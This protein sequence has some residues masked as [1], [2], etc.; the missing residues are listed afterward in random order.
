ML[1]HGVRHLPVLDAGR[2][3]IGVLDDVDLMASERRAPFRLRAE[4]AR[5]ADADAVA[6]A[7]AELPG[8]GDRPARRRPARRRDQP[9]DREHPRQRHPPADRARPCRSWARRRSPTPGWRWAASGASSRSRA[10]TSTARW[11]GRGRTTTRSCATGWRRSPSASSRGSRASG[12]RPDDQGAV[13]SSPLFARSIEA[14]EAA[15]RAWV[16]HPDRDRGLMLLS[17]AVES[18]PVWGATRGGRAHRRRVRARAQPRAAAHRLAAAALH[19]R[20]PTGF[21]RD[22]V[23]HSSGERKGVLDIKRGGLLPIES[24]ARWAGLAAGV[25]A[26]STRA[27]LEAAEAA[28]T[29]DPSRRRDPARR[30]RAASASCAWSTRSSSCAPARRPTT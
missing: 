19:E 4:I 14:W 21:L 8:D 5:S 24:L 10:P 23:L 25:S 26:A 29:L 16:E 20:P 2:R 22:F 17:V 30:L 15:A 6:A 7:A 18:D 12:L 13:A 9:R 3:L 27:R 1:D 28:G 11:P